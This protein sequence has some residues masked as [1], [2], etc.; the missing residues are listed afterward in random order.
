MMFVKTIRQRKQYLTPLACELNLKIFILVY[1]SSRNDW[2]AHDGASG[3]RCYEQI[4]VKLKNVN[5]LP[6]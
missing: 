3:S 6:N 1:E 2:S 4:S 5:Y